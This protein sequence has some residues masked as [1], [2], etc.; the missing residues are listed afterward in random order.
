MKIA[1]PTDDGINVSAHLGRA[2]YMLVVTL[3]DGQIADRQL[4][5]M[6][7]GQQQHDHS[8]DHHEHHHA[9]F[10]RVADC[11]MLVGGGMGQPAYERLLSMDLQVIMTD[12]KRV[13]DVLQAALQG[14]LSHNPRRIH[15]SHH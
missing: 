8:H 11:D 7:S 12:L 15:K 1:I 14:T 9:R 2:R 3:D 5:E 4:R 10:Q 6:G 13:D